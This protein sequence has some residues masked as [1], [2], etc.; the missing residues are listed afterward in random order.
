MS[1]AGIT[2]ENASTLSDGE[3]VLRLHDVITKKVAYDYGNVLV[4]QY[5]YSNNANQFAYPAVYEG[6]TVCAGYSRLFQILLRECGIH[7][8]FVMGNANNGS[9][10]GLH[11]WCKVLEEETWYNV[12]LTWDDL[13][14]DI[15]Y[16]YFN[17]SDELIGKDH[18]IDTPYYPYPSAKE[19]GYS[20]CSETYIFNDYDEI[21]AVN[22]ANFSFTIG[23]VTN[24]EKLCLNI[25]ARDK[26][27]PVFIAAYTSGGCFIDVKCIINLGAYTLNNGQDITVIKIFKL[28]ASSLPE[29]ANYTYIRRM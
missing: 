21:V 16:D 23:M 4:K 19:N 11:A 27:A 1:E 3:I 9:S 26:W 17:I 22:S 28:S 6:Y 5:G 25:I 8:V 14:Q 15:G 7:C 20:P 18:Y 12:D 13:D 10:V 2:A 29:C 24:E